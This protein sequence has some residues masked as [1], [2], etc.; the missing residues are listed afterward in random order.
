MSCTV[1]RG[2][3]SYNCPCCGEAHMTTCP[4]CKGSGYGPYK[5]WHIHERRTVECTSLAWLILPRDEDEAVARGENF[6]RM[7]RDYCHT[8]HGDGEIPIEH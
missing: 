3:D 2:H 7:Q 1:C 4:D 6:C 5:A 8:C